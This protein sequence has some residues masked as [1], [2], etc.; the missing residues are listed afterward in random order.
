ME[1]FSKADFDARGA[2][3]NLQKALIAGT[4]PYQFTERQLGAYLRY[5]R[6]SDKHWRVTPDFPEFEFRWMKEGSTRL[7]ALLAGEIHIADLPED[8]KGQATKQPGFQIVKGKVPALRTFLSLYCCQFKDLSDWSKGWAFPDTPLKDVRV[9]KALSRAINRD[10]LNKAFFAN[11][12]EIMVLNN[13]YP[14]RPGWNPDWEK[15]FRDEYGF[16]QAKAKA[17]LAESG[18]GPGKALTTNIVLQPVAGYSG[19]EDVAEAIAGYWRQIGVDVKTT[20]M[21]PAAFENSRR[22]LKFENDIVVDGTNATQWTGTLSYGSSL[23]VR[24]GVELA[25]LD[26][27]LKQLNAT[28]DEK[29]QAEKWRQVGDKRFE[30][31]LDVPLFWLPVEAV[32]NTKIVSDWLFPGS[33]TGSWSHVQNIKAAR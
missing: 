11:K 19:A 28:L 17:L 26:T 1:V 29:G 15:R 30:L 14:N 3:N 5:Q 24:R 18:F 32:V 16:D 2:A 23:G 12:G 10:E 31:A 7:A 22:A 6:A 25:E 20:P 33:L 13:F 27:L 9:R 8:L 21:D 4:G